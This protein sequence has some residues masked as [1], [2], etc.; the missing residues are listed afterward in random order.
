[1]NKG[2]AQGSVRRN[3]FPIWLILL[4]FNQAQ[5]AMRGLGS[6][7]GSTSHRGR[8]AMRQKT[9]LSSRFKR[10]TPVQIA[11]EKY[12][13]FVFSEIA[14]PCPRPASHEGRFA[15]VTKRRVRDAV[16]ASPRSMMFHADE[17][18]DAHG[19]VAWSRYPDAGIKFREM[20]VAHLLR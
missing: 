16:G 3:P 2:G 19:Q 7:R 4:V 1:M 6:A 15:V 8:N 9:H 5:M 17:R 11:R 10:I 13:A 18:G 14:V 20:R 12:F